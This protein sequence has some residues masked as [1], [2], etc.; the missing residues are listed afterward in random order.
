M[1]SLWMKTLLLTVALALQSHAIIGFGAHYTPAPSMEI[2]SNSG[3]ITPTGATN[4]ITLDLNGSSGLQ[5]LGVKLWLDFLPM[6][7][8]EVASNLQFGYYDLA[9]VQ[10][11][12]SHDVKFDLGIPGMKD[13][14]FYARSQTDVAI[15][16]PFLK[17]PPGISILK[18]YAGGGLSCGAATQTLS[19]KFA[20][21]ALANAPTTEYNPATDG[22]AEAT[23]VLVKAI[24]DEGM[25][26]GVGAFV[27]AGAHVKLPVIPI[28]AYADGKYRF[29][30][31]NPELIDGQDLSFELGVALAF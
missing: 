15:L 3:T 5:G 19:A 11:G 12:N 29:L 23:K 24:E 2:K 21:K 8:L 4:P 14:P 30:G 1:K 7:D 18:L 25:V 28:A 16:Y 9:V 26:S 20:K 13:S 10:S 31:S 27:Q 6:V 22:Y 17:L